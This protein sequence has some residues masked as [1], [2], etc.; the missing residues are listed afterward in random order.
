MGNWATWVIMGLL[1]CWPLAP[2]RAEAP[3]V[4]MEYSGSYTCIQGLTRLTLRV[5]RPSNAS[6]PNVIF[7]FGPD[8]LNPRVPNGEY[9]ARGSFDVNGGRLVLTPVHWISQPPGYTMI[10]LEGVSNDG[11]STFAGR[12]VGGAGCTTF[13]V[14]LVYTSAALQAPRAPL[15]PGPQRLREAA[16]RPTG[17]RV[18]V[19]L[20]MQS[21]IF[22][23]P[24]Q[25]NSALTLNFM[26]DSGA[27]DVSI[28]A[29]VVLTLMRTGT[30]QPTDFIGAQNYRLADGSTVPSATFRIRAL[31]I[32][33][34]EVHNVTGSVAPVN[35]ALLLGQSF[36]SRFSSWS[37]SNQERTLILE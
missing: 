30:L 20:Q 4:L 29:D 36:L 17:S 10:G 14:Q 1:W 21:G 5:L 26:I 34:R 35:G 12:I 6:D 23:V 27:S 19:P 25:I 16:S 11:G 22:L 37:I 2:G 28:P 13:S 8:V 33:S 18:E 3:P 31:K 7:A 15:L 9:W 32:G 24:V